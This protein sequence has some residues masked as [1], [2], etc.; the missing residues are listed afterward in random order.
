[1]A[2]GA[3]CQRRAVASSVAGL[4]A[5]GT[6]LPRLR[7]PRVESRGTAR[8]V[9]AVPLLQSVRHAD[10]GRDA[11]QTCARAGGCRS[12]RIRSVLCAVFA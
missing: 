5:V 11:R 6:F 10:G 7:S 8:L 1:M 9:F 3:A 12:Y 4:L 2:I